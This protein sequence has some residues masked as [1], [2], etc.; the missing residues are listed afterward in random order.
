MTPIPTQIP[1]GEIPADDDPRVQ[2]WLNML[3][4]ERHRMRAELEGLL[5]REENLR[6]YEQRLRAVQAAGGTRAAVPATPPSTA[7]TDDP[8]RQSAWDRLNRAREILETEQ[9]DLHAE[10]LALR[11]LEVAVKQSEERLA[12]R[13]QQLAEREAALAA[14][15]AATAAHSQERAC[16]IGTLAPTAMTLARSVLRGIKTT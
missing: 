15:E 13:E 14:A 5:Q 3:A 6:V 7:G 2:S 16:N 12:A 4:L 1:F 9:A 10:R 11:D 8:G